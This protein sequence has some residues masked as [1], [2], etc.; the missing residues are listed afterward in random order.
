MPKG[1][2]CPNG[3]RKN[4]KT[5]NCEP[6]SDKKAPKSPK[7]TTRKAKSPVDNNL[8]WEYYGGSSAFELSTGPKKKI[9]TENIPKYHKK[10]EERA[11]K[12]GMH[13]TNITR[14]NNKEMIVAKIIESCDCDRT[15]REQLED[16]DSV[17]DIL[18]LK[19]KDTNII[20]G[21]IYFYIDIEED[22][23]PNNDG[24]D[25]V[26][27]EIEVKSPIFNSNNELDKSTI[28]Q[29]LQ[30]KLKVVIDN[31]FVFNKKKEHMK[32]KYY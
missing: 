6:T 22:E 2:R 17:I 30:D 25:I 14:N 26:K 19:R 15:Q 32:V 5:G 24:K 28:Q 4:K 16:D 8:I 13:Y 9:F 27:V 12:Y 10:M 21:A 18:V 31:V 11:K 29:L 1:E 23:D 3:T 20:V 7:A